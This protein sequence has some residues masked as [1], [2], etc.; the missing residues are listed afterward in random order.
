MLEYKI[1]QCIDISN[2]YRK[3]KILELIIERK[4]TQFNFRVFI[5]N[6]KGQF[7]DAY[8][9]YQGTDTSSLFK[10]KKK[11]TVT[12]VIL[13]ISF[14]ILCSIVFVIACL[15]CCIYT[16]I[17][18]IIQLLFLKR[19]NNKLNRKYIL[20][21]E[22]NE[23]SDF[24]A[25]WKQKGLPS[26]IDEKTQVKC[27]IEWYKVIKNSDYAEE[28][29]QQMLLED[30]FF[31]ENIHKNGIR[32]HFVPTPMSIR[33]L[34][35]INFSLL[36]IVNNKNEATEF[37]LRE[38]LKRDFDMDFPISG[39]YGNSIDNP[40]VFENIGTNYDYVGYEY[41]ILECLGKG[42]RIEWKT[43]GQELINHNGL[44][45]DKVKIETKEI[46]ETEIITQIENYYFD[47]TNC[48]EKKKEF[49]ENELITSITKRLKDMKTENNFNRRCIKLLENGE[50][51]KDTKLTTEF[52]EVIFA[53]KSFPL[54]EEL[55]THKHTNIMNILRHIKF[56]KEAKVNT[57][58]SSFITANGEPQIVTHICPTE[59]AGKEM[60]K[61]ELHHFAVELLS[62]LYEKAGMT[63]VNVNRHY[64]RK[65]P[66]LIMKSKIG[67]LYYVII[68]SACYPQKAEY[69]C[70]FPEMK[71]LAKTHNATPVFAGISF[72]NASREWER[73]VCGD[74]YFVDFKELETI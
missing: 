43:K 12:R 41:S 26:D 11:N 4:K 25:L 14:L 42:R 16:P 62:D 24:I 1:K 69:S 51:F 35:E 64:D 28:K 33:L 72:M 34:N 31:W 61:E 73:L 29:Y 13:A 27:I 50:L 37:S 20:D 19:M 10:K 63:M 46:T 15:C 67:N 2:Q 38:L 21:Y 54:F 55:I 66:H 7:K 8:E 22:I 49:D 68:E 39:G 53:D 40:I 44:T 71:E 74:Q 6:F 59:R 36:D 65:F 18:F 57:K 9:I 23:C 56:E 52:L 48:F 5:N 58:V 17:R 30:A 45:V 60:T 3:K 47:I 70:D 32:M